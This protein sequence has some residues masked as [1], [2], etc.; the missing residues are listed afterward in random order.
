MQDLIN[1]NEGCRA[2]RRPVGQL[3]ALHYC[4]KLDCE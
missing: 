4:Y 2:L 3:A 1:V